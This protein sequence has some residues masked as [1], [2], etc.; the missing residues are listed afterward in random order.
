[1]DGEGTRGGVGAGRAAGAGVV[2]LVGRVLW[3]LW[4]RSRPVSSWVR[5]VDRPELGAGDGEV[6]GEGPVSSKGSLSRPI[7]RARSESSI[8]CSLL[9]RDSSGWM[10]SLSVGG[11]GCGG[12]CSGEFG[13][14]AGQLDVWLCLGVG[15]QCPGVSWVL[16]KRGDS[17]AVSTVLGFTFKCIGVWVGSDWVRAGLSIRTRFSAGV[18]TPGVVLEMCWAWASL[19]GV[20]NGSSGGVCVSDFCSGGLERDADLSSLRAGTQ[21]RL[22]DLF[23]KPVMVFFVFGSIAVTVPISLAVIVKDGLVLRA[24]LMM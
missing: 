18:R 17:R 8:A 13:T 21:V 2:D 6:W 12:D 22:P 19:I 4:K 11:L 9:W 24:M 1:M 20:W 3:F 16:V 7:S 14:V 5:G 15:G 23:R 10:A